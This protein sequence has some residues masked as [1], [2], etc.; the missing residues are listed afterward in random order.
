MGN[1]RVRQYASRLDRPEPSILLGLVRVLLLCA[2]AA[3]AGFGLPCLLA[4]VL[5]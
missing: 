5:P 3:G 4:S 1:R 2:I